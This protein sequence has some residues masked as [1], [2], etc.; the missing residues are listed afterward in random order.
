MWGNLCGWVRHRLPLMAADDLVG[1]DRRLVE[2]HLIGCSGCRHRLEGLQSA[3]NVLHQAAQVPGPAEVPAPS[4]WPA[5]ARQLREARRPT[6]PPAWVRLWPHLLAWSGFGLA[7]GLLVA[8]G[9][10]TQIRPTSPLPRGPVAT[11]SPP[12]SNP[13]SPQ[14]TT[15]LFVNHPRSHPSAAPDPGWRRDDDPR[16]SPPEPREPTY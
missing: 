9:L 12:T 4:L 14:P 7:A 15:P 8:L 16:P 2:R 13:A 10:L 3:L 1:P 5:L 11:A 6:S